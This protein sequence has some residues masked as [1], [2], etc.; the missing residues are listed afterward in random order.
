MPFLREAFGDEPESN[1]ADDSKE[2]LFR[3]PT[4]AAAGFEQL[5]SFGSLPESLRKFSD[6]RSLRNFLV[7]VRDEKPSDE[8]ALYDI[9][10]NGKEG[11]LSCFMWQRSLFYNKAR[12]SKK[13]WHLRWFS[14]TQN[15][16]RSVPNRS[17][18][19]KAGLR[20][21]KFSQFEFDDK[22]HIIRIPNP[23]NCKRKECK[24]DEMGWTGAII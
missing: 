18:Y 3:T 14:F 1:F 22:R 6:G 4:G 23:P 10:F 21:P 5:G 13:M 17:N 8:H 20:Y 19:K 11:R 9:E 15:Q 24:F 7:S 2:T 12:F 16:I